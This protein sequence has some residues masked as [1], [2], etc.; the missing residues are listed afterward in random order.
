[1]IIPDFENEYE[2]A[3]FIATQLIQGDGCYLQSII[4]MARLRDSIG[5]EGEYDK[6]FSIFYL[7]DD[8]TCHMPHDTSRDNCSQ[9]WLDK[10]D[11]ELKRIKSEHSHKLKSSCNQIIERFSASV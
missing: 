2:E 1:M 3:V 8:A 6:D 11:S 4:R 5:L 7:I 9:E 10:C